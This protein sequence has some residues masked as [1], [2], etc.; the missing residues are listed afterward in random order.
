MEIKI[1]ITKLSKLI[2][3]K[4]KEQL[5]IEVEPIIRRTYAGYWQ[6]KAGAWLWFMKR[7]DTAGDIGSCSRAR[8]FS[9]GD[10]IVLLADGEVDID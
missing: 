6:T 1:K 3:N 2:A 4:L 8:D 5:D 9:K 10:K 7:I